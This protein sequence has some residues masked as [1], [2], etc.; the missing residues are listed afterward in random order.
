MLSPE[1]RAVLVRARA[2][3]DTPEKWCHV[4]GWDGERVCSV[5]AICEARRGVGVNRDVLE[6]ALDALRVAAGLGPDD[7]VATWNDA[8]ERTHAEVLA[9]FDRALGKS[10]DETGAM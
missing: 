3:I 4:G 1:A 7:D 5:V 9:A 6:E 8:P 10:A 2:R